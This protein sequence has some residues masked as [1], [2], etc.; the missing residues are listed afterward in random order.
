MRKFFNSKITKIFI[1]ILVV[2]LIYV[3][4]C[5]LFV[6]KNIED[7]GFTK[8]YNTRL[9][10]KEQKNSIDI[11]LYGNSD[12]SSGIIPMQM[13]KEEGYT[14]FLRWG[15]QQT[16]NLVYKNL[17]G[18]FK[19]QKPKIVV[20]EVDCVYYP[21][22]KI[23]NNELYQS[24]LLS[25]FTYHSRWKSLDFKDIICKVEYERDYHKGYNYKTING[26]YVYEDYMG[27]TTKIEPIEK[28]A[29]KKIKQIKKLCD[30]NKAELLFIEAPSP[31]SWNMKKHNGIKQL[32]QQ[33]N[34]NFIDFN[35]ELDGFDFDY[36]NDFRDYGNHCNFKG[37][38]KVTSYVTK[39]IKENYNVPDRR[40]DDSSKYKTWKEDLLK[41][42]KVYA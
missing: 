18:D 4:M 20:L 8:Y 3:Y 10:T 11:L 38:T 2:A 40:L 19:I 7:R 23:S 26:N 37:A 12:L 27:F 41:F 16:L 28:S 24:F 42:D 6:P 22:K 9:I 25:P 34:V 1:T 33:L 36:A 15:N 17:K 29:L 31:S 13:Y 30:K 14:S 35:L 32:A 39:Y 5:F 21:N